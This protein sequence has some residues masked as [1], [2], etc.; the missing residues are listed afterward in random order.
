MPFVILYTKL[1]PA[2]PP[3]GGLRSLSLVA[4]SGSARTNVC[5][6]LLGNGC[7]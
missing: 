3:G 4:G 6:K 1:W 7:W 2:M 5:G